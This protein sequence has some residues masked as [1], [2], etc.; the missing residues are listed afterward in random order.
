MTTEIMSL[1]PEFFRKYLDSINILPSSSDPYLDRPQPY[2]DRPQPYLEWYQPADAFLRVFHHS[3]S[4]I[5][6]VQQVS[7]N[8]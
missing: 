1:V 2:L 4:A 8:S 6:Q 5:T 3:D 7:L